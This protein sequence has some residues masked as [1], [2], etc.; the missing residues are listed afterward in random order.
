VYVTGDLEGG[1]KKKKK[2]VYTTKKKNKHIHKKIKL[3][4]LRFIFI[5]EQGNVT[6]Q[7]KTCPNCGPGTFM[8]QHWDRY[9]C[10]LCHTTIKMD[11][12]TVKKNY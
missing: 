3:L 11:A 5:L 10:G 7:R 9:Y 12:E 4:P 6:Q 1:K 2:K 8:A